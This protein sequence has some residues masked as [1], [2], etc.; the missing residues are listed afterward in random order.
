LNFEHCN[1]DNVVYAQTATFHT[2]YKV[3]SY[4]TTPLKNILTPNQK[5][6][7]KKK[8]TILTVKPMPMKMQII[9][10]VM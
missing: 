8:R 3:K 7:E 1:F 9:P 4:F 6:K 5:K 10:T 2:N